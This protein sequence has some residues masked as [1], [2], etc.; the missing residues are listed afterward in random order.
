M[1][2]IFD[3]KSIVNR[4]KI[5]EVPEDTMIL[6]EGEINLDM[7]KI[8]SGH[9]EMYTG[10]GTEDEVLIGWLGPGT[11][12]G[13]FGVL[14]G[15]PAIYTII[16]YS[17]TKIIRVTEGLMGDFIQEYH[18]DI[19]QIMRNMASSMTKMQQQIYQLHKELNE[20]TVE[21][22][23]LRTSTADNIKSMSDRKKI[24]LTVFNGSKELSLGIMHYTTQINPMIV[25]IE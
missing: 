20:K 24:I 3:G 17:K 18:E 4:N 12:F 13:E 5:Y 7:Y 1:A 23:S 9:V 25:S 19:L 21:C 15:Q 10:Y 2:N 11:C 6:K 14:T 16:T 22:N 8:V